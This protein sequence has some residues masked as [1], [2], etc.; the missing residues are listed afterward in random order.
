MSLLIRSAT[1]D[2]T[3]LILELIKG[4]A[5][6]ERL[7]HEVTATETGLRTALFGSTPGAEVLIAE[8]QGQSAGFALYFH[9]FSTF[10][11]RRGIWLEDLFVRPAN[12]GVGIGRELL[13]ALARV[14]VERGC[15]RLEWAVLDW[16]EDAIRF[17]RS[18]GAEAKDEWTTYRLTET[19]LG[20]LAVGEDGQ[21][22]AIP[23]IRA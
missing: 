13:R 2:D 1:M 14:A 16:N 6:Y 3:P 15:G 23:A 7:P 19:G 17:Y 22:L 11:G 5:E 8:W 4:L 10:L 9:T 20:R 21:D 18:L 12:R